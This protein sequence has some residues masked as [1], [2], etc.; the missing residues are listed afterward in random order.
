M[1]KNLL[2]ISEKEIGKKINTKKSFKEND[3]DSLDLMTFLALFEDYYNI[4]LK[5]N[6]YRAI[7][8]F[9]DLAKFIKK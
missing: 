2:K 4:K 8:S 7:K 5:E 9:Y 3:F 1:D 6:D